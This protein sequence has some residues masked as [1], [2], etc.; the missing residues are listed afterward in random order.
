MLLP[1]HTVDGIADSV[2]TGSGVTET[3]VEA[4]SLGHPLSDTTT[5]YAPESAAV[6][7]A[8]TNVGFV[9]LNIPLLGV[10]NT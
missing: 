5:E 7:F 3:L 1:A 4:G 6:A 2:A 9:V 8:K 10:L